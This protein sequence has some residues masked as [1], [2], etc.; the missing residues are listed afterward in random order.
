[1]R[2]AGNPGDAYQGAIILDNLVVTRRAAFTTSST[3][4][5][6]RSCN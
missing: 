5:R 4:R 2:A 6:S 1:M 3:A